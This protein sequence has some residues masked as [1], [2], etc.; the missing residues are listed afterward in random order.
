M[1]SCGPELVFLAEDG[2]HHDQAMLGLF[3]Q[4]QDT[5]GIGLPHAILANSST[6]DFMVMSNPGIE[7]T[8]ENDLVI[9]G[10]GGKGVVEVGVKHFLD[11]LIRSQSW[12]I[13]AD[14]SGALVLAEV[15]MKGHQSFTDTQR[16]F[17]EHVSDLVSD[18]KIDSMD[19]EVMVSIFR[20]RCSLH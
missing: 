18:G 14:D 1:P 12:N 13:C 5:I 4:E 8:Q 9:P 16:E 11:F 7:V 2:V 6:P 15:Q 17:R 19:M 20:R 3:V 10:Y